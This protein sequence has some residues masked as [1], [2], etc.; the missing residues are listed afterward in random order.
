ME[1]KIINVSS[2]KSL[3]KTEIDRTLTD[4]INVLNG[5]LKKLENDRLHDSV[6]IYGIHDKRLYNRKV[7]HAYIKKICTLLSLDYRAV[8][9]SEYDKNH[10]VVKLSDAVAAKEWQSRSREVRLKN[11]DLDVAY[12]GPVKIFVAATAEH[13]QLLKKT[14]DALLPIYKY[15]SLCKKGVMVRRNDR[16][17][18]Y[19]VTHENDISMLLNKLCSNGDDSDGSELSNIFK[20]CINKI[21]GN[22]CGHDE[23]DD[24]AHVFL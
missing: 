12:D 15:V 16:S 23:I 5:K 2:L 19:V 4:N 8:V 10:I 21:R 18:I 1:N 7:R 22:D 9:E 6:E 11:V 20:D 13:K 17:K 14:R 3:I 24:G